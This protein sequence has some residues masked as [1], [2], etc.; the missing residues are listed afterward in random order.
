MLKDFMF[1]LPTKIVS[2]RGGLSELP[3]EARSLKGR[4]ILIVTDKGVRAAGIVDRV[5]THLNEGGFRGVYIFDDVAPN[6]RT[7]EVNKGYIYAKKVEANL[8]IAV[9]GGSSIDTAK[10]IGILIGNGGQ[11]EEYEGIDKLKKPMPPLIAIPTTVGTGSEVTGF[12]VI[13]DL[14]RKFKLTIG[15]VKLSPNVAILDSDLVASLPPRI[16]A[17]TSMDALS[18]AIEGYV[19]KVSMPVT[20]AIALYAIELI[21]KNIRT[22]VYGDDYE[23]KANLQLAGML[24]GIVISQTDVAS[25]HCM[26]EALGGMY[27]T[28]H[29]IANASILPVVMAYNAIADIDKYA[30]IAKCL[31]IDTDHMTKREA[32]I[33]SAHAVKEL[34]EDLSIPSLSEIG[35]R[36][37][38]M[39]TLAEK[40]EANMSNSVNPRAVTSVEYLT[41]F[42]KAYEGII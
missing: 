19:C 17:A 25:V 20:D 38:D 2:G 10:G 40:A 36:E 22:A 24:A 21:A 14:K 31:G 35:V 3:S 1:H 8:L 12:A 5:V 6:P 34:N 27:D 39:R 32:A 30:K 33:A 9:G 7:D 13:T 37:E 28:A 15:D 4:N 26:G 18:H 16:I 41:L 11:I 29:G 42:K 23:A